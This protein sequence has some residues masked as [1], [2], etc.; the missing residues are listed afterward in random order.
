MPTVIQL[1]RNS[2]FTRANGKKRRIDS[3]DAAKTGVKY[4]NEIYVKGKRK[5]LR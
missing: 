4:F 5:K 3:R 2:A 1:G